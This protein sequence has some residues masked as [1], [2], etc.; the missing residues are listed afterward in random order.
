[1]AGRIEACSGQLGH[2]SG[3]LRH[4]GLR[5]KREAFQPAAS[6]VPAVMHHGPVRLVDRMAAPVTRKQGGFVQLQL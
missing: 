4:A 1:V 3:A 6:W 2:R 5:W